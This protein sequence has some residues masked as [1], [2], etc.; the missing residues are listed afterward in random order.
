MAII[1]ITELPDDE[2]TENDK[3]GFEGRRTY[4]VKTDVSARPSIALS[5][6]Y[7]PE[8]GGM[9]VVPA[10]G[11]PFDTNYTGCIL[12]TKMAK[13]Y[14]GEDCLFTVECS[15]ATP[16]DD[17]ATTTPPPTGTS[18]LDEL[19]EISLSVSE[20]SEAY[21]VDCRP[22]DPAHP[23]QWPGPQYVTNSAGECF[24]GDLE[25]DT[26]SDVISIA[27]NEPT[28]SLDAARAIRNTVNDRAIKVGG[29]VF[30]AFTLRLK[31]ITATLATAK[32]PAPTIENPDATQTITYWKR[33]YTLL[34]KPEGWTDDV[35]DVGMNELVADPLSTVA[36]PL[37]PLLRPIMDSAQCVIKKPVSLNGQGQRLAYPPGTTIPASILSDPTKA[38]LY[39]QGIGK[40]YPYAAA[41]WSSLP[42]VEAI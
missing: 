14:Q 38:Y 26:A 22:F 11:T 4:L 9:V 23:L 7:T 15:Y 24:D 40:F 8:T 32:I 30:P 10:R 19:P 29:K 33:S 17:T 25:R 41:D 5:A 18:P 6:F 34:W 27:T 21:F 36:V 20:G 37:P 1:S 3:G 28:H 13:R 42:F 16:D 2:I 31:P 39:E 35:L 12:K